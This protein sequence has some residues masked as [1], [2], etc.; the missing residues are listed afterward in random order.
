MAMSFEDLNEMREVIVGGAGRRTS[1][2]ERKASAEPPRPV[3]V[4]NDIRSEG[5]VGHA[6]EL[7]FSWVR[8]VGVQQ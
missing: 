3:S 6:E 5:F 4:T 2:T 8:E 1:S 7:A